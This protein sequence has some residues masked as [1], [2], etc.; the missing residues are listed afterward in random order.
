MTMRSLRA[1]LVLGAFFALTFPLM[2]LQLL[3]LK[4]GSRY[5]RSFPHWY[6]RQVCKIV[7][8][9]LN[10]EGEVAER[11]GRADHLQP[12]LLARHHRALGRGAGVVRGEARGRVL[13]LR[14]LAR[15]AAA[16]GVRRPQPA[17]RGRRQGE[18]DSG[19]ARRR[20][21]YRAVRRRNL[22]RRQQR[23]AVQDRIVRRGQACRR[24]ADGRQGLG[25]DPRA[26]LSP[27]S[28]GCRFAAAD[29]T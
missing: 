3:F 23:G 11:A 1:F 20:R 7:G 25:A 19:A 10:V 27:R 6:H 15:Q 18:R 17:E 9:R 4:T 12:C 5:A 28:M 24:R 29:A 13:A 26:H 8:I 16:L 14:Q 22:E 21:P 2:P